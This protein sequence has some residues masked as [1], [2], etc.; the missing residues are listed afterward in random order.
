MKKTSGAEGPLGCAV[1]GGLSG[2]I[3]GNLSE[4]VNVG[5]GLTLSG[6]DRTIDLRRVGQELS[7]LYQTELLESEAFASLSELPPPF[8][9]AGRWELEAPGS[10]QAHPFRVTTTLPPPLEVANFESLKTI[11]RAEDFIVR[12]SPQGNTDAEAVEVRITGR[13]LESSGEGASD[14]LRTVSCRSPAAAGELTVPSELLREYDSSWAS[15]SPVPTPP[16]LGLSLMPRPGAVALFSVSLVNGETVPSII[17]CYS[18]A[19]FAVS[20]R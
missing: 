20:F 19:F 6:E 17:R 8:F 9:T 18:G 4:H 10:H 1:S 3:S 7:A 13:E 14:T 5:E 11:D 12:W 16:M 15:T 2:L